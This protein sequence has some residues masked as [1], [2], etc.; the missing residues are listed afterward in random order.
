MNEPPPDEPTDPEERRQLALRIM[1]Q[2]YREEGEAA[3]RRSMENNAV[4]DEVIEMLIR[5]IKDMLDE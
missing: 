4:S 3:L 1:A 2:I 5:Q